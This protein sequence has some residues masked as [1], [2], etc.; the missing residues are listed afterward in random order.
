M[1]RRNVL[2][3]VA[4]AALIFQA[5]AAD[6]WAA[7]SQ[8]KKL[9]TGKGVKSGLEVALNPDTGDMLVVYEEGGRI[10]AALARNKKGKYSAKKA[11]VVSSG[12]E[13]YRP[14]AAWDAA[15]GEFVVAWDTG[16]DDLID[17]TL[18]RAVDP[19]DISARRVKAKT[20]KGTK[21]EIS[22]V[23]DGEI[24]L[25][26]D[27]RRMPDGEVL[28]HFVQNEDPT[29][30]LE[31]SFSQPLVRLIRNVFRGVGDSPEDLS[32]LPVGLAIA[33]VSASLEGGVVLGFTQY[34]GGVSTALAAFVDLSEPTMISYDNWTPSLFPSVPTV[35][36]AVAPFEEEAA[37]RRPVH[38]GGQFAWGEGPPGSPL[39]PG[40]CERAFTQGLDPDDPNGV[41]PVGADCWA[42]NY[43]AAS[44]EP[45]R[46]GGAP[47]TVFGAGAAMDGTVRLY[48]ISLTSVE[49]VAE[50]FKR[51][52]DVL[53]LRLEALPGGE[54]AMLVWIEA[55]TKKKHQVW[56][57]IFDLP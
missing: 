20:G 41:L 7:A 29:A 23:S 3:A 26:P 56:M 25:G 49:V 1:H 51:K 33:E 17:A 46:L 27:L 4:C 35:A 2:V 54:R 21:P 16:P 50:L 52:K 57:H 47:A 5:S 39:S 38:P 14:T 43:C 18:R 31:R 11:K 13:N 55:K 36:T 42:S 15:A 19:A 28:L 24:N 30:R 9:K 48:E 12:A 34:V 6:A 53:E 32:T 44:P 10:F 22:V 8:T 45:L 37:G 40:D